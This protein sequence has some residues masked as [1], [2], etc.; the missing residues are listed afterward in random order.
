MKIGQSRQL[1]ATKQNLYYSRNH[2][3]T[4]LG[5]IFSISGV[6]DL[7]VFFDLQFTKSQMKY[8]SA[9]LI[10]TGTAYYEKSKIRSFLLFDHHLGHGDERLSRFDST[11]GA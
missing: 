10:D 8:N 4:C 7:C 3:T 9:G 6:F 11:R 5:E 1:Q 2:L